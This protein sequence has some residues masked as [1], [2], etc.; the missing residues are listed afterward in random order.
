MLSQ[1]GFF[2]FVIFIYSLCRFSLMKTAFIQWWKHKCIIKSVCRYQMSSTFLLAAS[3][4]A[5]NPC[6]L[7]FCISDAI[8]QGGTGSCSKAPL[9]GS[10]SCAHC[11]VQALPWGRGSEVGAH[12]SFPKTVWDLQG[13]EALSSVSCLP[14]FEIFPTVYEPLWKEMTLWHDEHAYNAVVHTAYLMLA[15]PVWVGGWWGKHQWC[16]VPSLKESLPALW[17]FYKDVFQ[18]GNYFPRPEICQ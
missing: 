14:F 15:F 1:Q 8:W 12:S 10:F 3:L 18:S 6:W 4:K 13:V 9:S 2:I 17:C 5:S 11:S 16:S 7:L